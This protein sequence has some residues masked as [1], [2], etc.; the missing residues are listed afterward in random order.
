MVVVMR[1]KLK[2]KIVMRTGAIKGKPM[3]LTQGGS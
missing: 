2:F 3:F 1:I